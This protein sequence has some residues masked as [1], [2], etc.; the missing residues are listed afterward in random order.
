M[1]YNIYCDE[2]CHLE[3]DGINVMVLGAVYCPQDKIQN[4]NSRIREIK[5]RH[6][7]H[8]DLELKWTKISP[9]KVDVY[10]ELVNYFFDNSD[11]HFRVLVV[12]DKRKLDHERFNQDHNT[13]YYK[14][15][16]EM[17]KAILSP[18]DKYNIYIDIKD[19]HSHDR[20]QTLRKV[21]SNSMYDFSQKVITKL[22]PV[23]SEEVQLM[24]IVDI[25]IGAI[26]YRNREFPD[27]FIKSAA[28]QQVIKLIRSRSNYALNKTTLLREDKFNIFVWEAR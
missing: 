28:K 19:T 25:L 4:V 15:Y 20:A 18:R 10:L 6:G 1:E 17:L 5:K 7:I 9:A 27:G 11:L 22:Q 24:Q 21:C 13:W 2:S 12:P 26:A 8:A 14:M 23:R 16:F 3:N